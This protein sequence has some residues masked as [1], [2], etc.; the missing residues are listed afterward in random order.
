MD[1][2]VTPKG[3]GGADEHTTV[4]PLKV[5]FAVHTLAGFDHLRGE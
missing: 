4:K 2:G 5:V 3:M 1:Y